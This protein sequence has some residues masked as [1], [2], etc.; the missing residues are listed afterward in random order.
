MTNNQLPIHEILVRAFAWGCFLESL[1]RQS[2]FLHFCF[3]TFIAWQGGCCDHP[4]P[5]KNVSMHPE[6]DALT[7]FTSIY[8]GWK[9]IWKNIGLS[10]PFSLLLMVVCHKAVSLLAAKL[11]ACVREQRHTTIPVTMGNVQHEMWVFWKQKHTTLII[12]CSLEAW[13]FIQLETWKP[14]TNSFWLDSDTHILLL[15]WSINAE[16]ETEDSLEGIGLREAYN[17]TSYEK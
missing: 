8:F 11:E 17:K 13:I 15:I 2:C 16:H 7:W 1:C 5:G 4:M 3:S 9:L 14:N 12:T 10:F 6:E